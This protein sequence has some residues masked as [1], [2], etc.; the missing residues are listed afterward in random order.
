MALIKQ[1]YCYCM[2]LPLAIWI[3]Y[4]L[5]CLFLA[6][7]FV[8][9]IVVALSKQFPACME[10]SIFPCRF[11]TN[12][13]PNHAFSVWHLSI[14]RRNSLVQTRKSSIL[15]VFFFRDFPEFFLENSGLVLEIRPRRFT[16]EWSSY[17]LTLYV[18]KHAPSLNKQREGKTVSYHAMKPYMG[19]VEV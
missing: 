1:Y 3:Q 6:E 11:F 9:L 2:T 8:T 15:V 19:G 18:R 10:H 5:S 14:A 17:C 13:H 16:I 4:I 12:S 7:P